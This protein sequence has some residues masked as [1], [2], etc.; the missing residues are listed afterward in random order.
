MNILKFIILLFSSIFAFIFL[1]LAF[2]SPDGTPFFILGGACFILTIVCARSLNKAGK[3]K[4]GETKKDT[5]VG[6]KKDGKFHGQGTYTWSDGR[7]YEGEWKDAK[8]DGK[9]TETNS[10]G[11]SYEGEWK[12]NMR[13]G[14]GIDIY[15]SGRKYE[16]NWKENTKNGY[17]VDTLTDGGKYEGEWVNNDMNGQG[18]FTYK[19]GDVYEGEWKDRKRHGQGTFTQSNGGKIIGEWKSGKCWDGTL[20]N[21]NGSAAYIYQEGKEISIVVINNTKF[22]SDNNLTILPNGKMRDENY[23][24]YELE[25]GSVDFIVYKPEGMRGMRAYIKTDSEKN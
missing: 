8:R 20:Y 7:K 9:G 2:T 18:T 25:E 6:E 15:P 19:D 14:Q 13:S 3:E 5:Y 4:G 21:E 12:D 17:G 24:E 22:L 11:Y 10:D 23:E 16:G 1:M